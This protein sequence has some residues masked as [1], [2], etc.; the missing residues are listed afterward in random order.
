MAVPCYWIPFH[1]S[2]VPNCKDREKKLTHSKWNFILHTRMQTVNQKVRFTWQYIELKHEEQKPCGGEAFREAMTFLEEG[3]QRRQRCTPFWFYGWE[4]HQTKKKQ[5][6]IDLHSQEFVQDR[7]RNWIAKRRMLFTIFKVILIHYHSL[8]FKNLY[9]TL[10]FLNIAC[11][12][13][14]VKVGCIVE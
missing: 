3:I 4:L 10:S 8:S 14:H 13:R 6:A 7:K 11:N 2:Y 5:E 12:V 9:G 1:S